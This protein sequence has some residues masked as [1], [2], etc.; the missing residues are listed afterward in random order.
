MNHPKRYETTD[1][2]NND[3]YAYYINQY[4][5][6]YNDIIS[7][8]C[9]EL[10]NQLTL[11][12]S[13]LQ[14]IELKHPEINDIKYWNSLTNDVQEGIE[15]L[16]NFKDF[17][18]HTDIKTSNNDLL[19]VIESAVNSLLPI[20]EEKNIPL[21]LWVDEDCKSHYLN[22]PFDKHKIKSAF[23]N[24]IKNAL[25]ATSDGGYVIIHQMILTL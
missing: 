6:Y 10:N 4:H 1:Y 23:I 21:S 20:A 5:N 24:I 18:D 13:A 25:E 15:L 8:M 3:E 11:I 9:H 16:N 14:L 19:K 17:R 2:P 22:Y 12:N 7:K